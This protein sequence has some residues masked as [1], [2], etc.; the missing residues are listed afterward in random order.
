MKIGSTL[1]VIDLMSEMDCDTQFTVTVID[2]NEKRFS[3]RRVK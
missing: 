1:E 2:L 3:I